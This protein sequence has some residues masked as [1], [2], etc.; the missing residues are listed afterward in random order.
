MALRRA[1]WDFLRAWEPDLGGVDPL[2]AA[3]F[4]RY[5]RFGP[6]DRRLRLLVCERASGHILGSISLGEMD[7]EHERASIGYWIG[8]VH[9][10]RGY[11]REALPLALGF[12]AREHALAR[13]EAFVLPENEAS[14]RLLAGLGFERAGVAR[15]YREMG[16]VARDHER[17]IIC[18][19]RAGSGSPG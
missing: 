11:M 7:I 4:R 15:A 8:A 16:G 5:M 13:V 12:A 19:S 14:L 9:A 1:S 18:P 17:W 3:W 10:R 6:A 2:G